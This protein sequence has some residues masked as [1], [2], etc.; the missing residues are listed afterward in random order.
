MLKNWMKIIYESRLSLKPFLHIVLQPLLRDK[1][2][3]FIL[4]GSNATNAIPK[5]M[6]LNFEIYKMK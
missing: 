5:V 4:E 1:E 6:I 2:Q 3:N